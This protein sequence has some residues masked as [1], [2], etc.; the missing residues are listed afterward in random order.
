M[1]DKNKSS[2]SSSSSSNQSSN[3]PK[4]GTQLV[5]KD[6]GKTLENKATTNKK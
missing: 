3:G 5:Q 4:I 1:S 6:A 2:S